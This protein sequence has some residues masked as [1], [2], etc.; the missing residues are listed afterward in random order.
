MTSYE[1]PGRG[2]IERA[3]RRVYD[4]L[5][6]RNRWIRFETA[7]EKKARVAQADAEYPQAAAALAQMVLGPVAERLTMKRLLIVSDG[8]LQ[9]VPFAA[10]P[11]PAGERER[12][13]AGERGTKKSS[14][15]S[16]TSSL[17][18]SFRPLVVDHEIVKLPSASTL[19]VLRRELEER[20]PAPKS[21]A[22][23]ADP[24]FDRND[25]RFTASFAASPSASFGASFAR[26]LTKPGAES[27]ARVAGME[28]N[29]D[30]V[31]SARDI[32]IDG[33]RLA[34][35]PFT[36]KEA[37]A[38]LELAP[39]RERLAALDFAASQFTVFKP[40][41][42]QYRY[43]HIATHGLLNSLRPELSGIVLS[44]VN[45]R[46]VD[47]DGFLRAHEVF[48]LRL[49]AEMV[50]LSGCQ[51]GLGKEIKGEGLVGL[52]R[53]F[54]YAG[55]ARVMVSLWEVNDQATSQLMTRLYQGLL[56]KR[57]LSPA[58][59]LREAQISFWRDKRWSSP[60]YW[61]AFTLQG[62]PR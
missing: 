7:D 36:R 52:T 33:Y 11:A 10:L 32:G 59:A 9:Y 12:G 25:E 35:L 55:A 22:V 13:R 15:L 41:L 40:E 27:N 30:L 45:E 51:T 48:D 3:S 60:Y 5:T 4:L 61:A 57:R 56:G 19:A 50:V 1:L 62:E 46:G 14:G 54:M 20:A 49:P 58:A 2:E 34:R 43:V 53:G 42:A 38:I 39:A 47:Q 8:A 17:P 24:V 37:Q 28:T 6:A 18:R 29:S 16:L 23:L 44:L 26:A 31:R 21:V